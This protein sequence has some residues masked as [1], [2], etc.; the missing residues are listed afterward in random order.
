MS[1]ET[2]QSDDR[3]V[4]KRTLMFLIVAS[5]LVIAGAGIAV[6][7]GD[8]AVNL[9]PSSETVDVGNTTTFDVVVEDADVGVRS[10]TFSVN[11]SDPGAASIQGASLNGDPGFD[12]VI[13]A[14]DGSSIEV[15]AATADT[16]NDSGAVTIAT[17]TVRGDADGS[18]DPHRDR[19][20]Q[21]FQ[22]A[23][24]WVLG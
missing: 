3:I 8:T 14:D 2:T 23:V 24:R 6:A 13:I 1:I 7:A 9:S 20:R 12:E 11:L 10:Y 5:G 21:R 15:T 17:I 19:D 16:D 22:W 18:T 4:A